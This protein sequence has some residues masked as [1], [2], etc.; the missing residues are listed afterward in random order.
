[1]GTGNLGTAER[2][3]IESQKDLLWLQKFARRLKRERFFGEVVL[4]YQNGKLVNCSENK[5][6]KPE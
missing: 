1:M 2:K 3:I 6:Y 4:T 5:N